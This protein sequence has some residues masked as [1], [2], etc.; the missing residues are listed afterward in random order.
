MLAPVSASAALL[1]TLTTSPTTA[2]AHQSTTFTFTASNLELLGVLGCLEV[3]LPGSFLIEATGTPMASNGGTWVATVSGNAVLVH[4]VDNAGRLKVANSVTFTVRAQPTVAGSFSL[5][6]HSH[7][8]YDCAGTAQPGVALP[9]TVL[10]GA[11]PTPVPT[12]TPRPTAKPTPTPLPLP[13]LPLPTL[14]IPTVLPTAPPPGATPTPRPTG[15]AVFGASPSGSVSATAS[16]R[17][18]GSVA[19]SGSSDP[20]APGAGPAGGGGPGAGG[21][22][23]SGPP[24][25]L[26]PA[27]LQLNVQL[28]DLLGSPQVWFVPAAAIGAPGLLVLL[29]VLLQTVG[30]LAWIPFV[31]RMRG[32]EPAR[33][34]RSR[35]V[36][37]R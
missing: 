26:E 29:W 7:V 27:D 19:P 28:F 15:G 4:S 22:R 11:T 23:G 24:V 2:V 8:R 30:T 17:A 35:R 36:S 6:N 12:P 25:R 3:D 21:T 33:I 37:V 31:R 10:P 18:S 1:W 34:G 13:S 32:R 20:A 14:P 5:P 16:P 9:I